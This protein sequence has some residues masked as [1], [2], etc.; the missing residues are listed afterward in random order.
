METSF[1]IFRNKAA[2]VGERETGQHEP[3]GKL[4]LLLLAMAG[5]PY[6]ALHTRKESPSLGKCNKEHEA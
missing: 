3:P 2:G 5:E 6:L 1:F 4:L